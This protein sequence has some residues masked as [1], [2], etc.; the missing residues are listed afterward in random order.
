MDIEEYKKE[1]KMEAKTIEKELK[2]I[3]N[4][5]LDKTT[6][7]LKLTHSGKEL[8]LKETLSETKISQTQCN[9]IKDK[10]FKFFKSLMCPLKYFYMLF[11]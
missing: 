5:K 3:K 8:E 1:K 7:T 2:L 4:S 10:Y 6:D 9:F 11:F